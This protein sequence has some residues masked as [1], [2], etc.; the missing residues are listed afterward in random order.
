MVSDHDESCPPNDYISGLVLSSCLN[1]RFFLLGRQC[2]GYLLKSGLV[3][4]QYVKTA[5]VR[6]YS[7]LSDV[8]GAMEILLYCNPGLQLDTCSYNLIL[9]GLVEK[10]CLDEALIMLRRMLA[11]E[12]M[13]WNKATYIGVFGLCALLKDLNLGMQV[14][15]KLLKSYHFEPDESVCSTMMSMYV[16]C[17]EILSARKVFD[18]RN[19]VV[20]WTA[21]LAAYL[22]HGSFEESFKLF[23]VMRHKDVVPNESTFS[24]VLTVSAELFSRRCGSMLH[25]L[26]E[27]TGLK[28]HK[29]VEDALINMYSRTGD[30]KAAEKVFLGM[31][32][33]RDV[34]TW[35]TMINGYCYHGLG[36]ESLA[37]FQEM[38]RSGEDP[39]DVTF[40]GVLS[41]CGHVGLVE[42][43]FYYLYELMKQK[44]VK[45][46]LDHY[47]CIINMLI[48][49]GQLNEA[50]SFIVS[51][52]S[53][54][55]V[56]AW[57][58]LLSAFRAH[59]L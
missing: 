37:L 55:D 33:Y 48:K 10:G 14:H 1:V 15:N 7:L 41:A 11:E 2:H 36:N 43:G 17:G 3:F 42:Q 25:A 34:T 9:I 53:K 58:S 40:V 52:P 23:A 31:T 46:G 30:I 28:V 44:G 24:V 59:D 47:M 12:D 45:P 35:N 18:I 49:A 22:E 6:L 57:T 39:N 8:I 4:N 13:V 16:K 51:T 29:N 5:L 50:L 38:L 21:M 20:I 27:K 32:N 26:T 19:N 54:W 56:F